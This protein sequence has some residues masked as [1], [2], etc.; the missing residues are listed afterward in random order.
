MART[1]SLFES[2]TARGRVIRQ[3]DL[4]CMVVDGGGSIVVPMQDFL[5]AQKWAQS[6]PASGNAVTD[7]G[8]FLEQ[9]ATVVARPGSFCQTRGNDKQLGSLAKQMRQ[10][11]YDL[12]EW[13]LPPELKSNPPPAAPKPRAAAPAAD[14]PE[15]GT[16]TP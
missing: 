10:A 14:P 8:R 4:V 6:K 7:R 13:S 9:F 1:L 3:A 11:G 15:P 12:N 5:Q 2:A 16:P